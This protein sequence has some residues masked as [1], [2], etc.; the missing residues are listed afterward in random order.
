MSVINNIR[1]NQTKDSV[2]I[3]TDTG[4]IVYNLDPFG[5]KL[6]RKILGGLRLVQMLYNSNLYIL[7]GD[8]KYNEYYSNKLVIWNDEKSQN[9][10]EIEYNDIIKNVECREDIMVVVL[11]YKT[12]IYNSSDYSRLREIETCNNPLGLITINYSINFN[13]KLRLVS[14]N[15]TYGC[16]DI[17]DK[18]SVESL[19]SI[20]AHNN[21][22][23]CIQLNNNGEYLATA[24]NMGTIIRLFNI[25]NGE[26]IS[27]FR[28]SIY[29]KI[30]NNLIFNEYSNLLL[31]TTLC[32]S[33]DIFKTGLNNE[34]N[35]I[36]IDEKKHLF[37]LFRNNSISKYKM[38]GIKMTGCFLG[39]SI[40]ML[41]YNSK[42]YQFKYETG[43]KLYNITNLF[44]GENS[45]I[46]N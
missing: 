23:E 38:N 31:C 27:E 44:F 15:K 30:V 19:R 42:Y 2:S 26:M 36:Q 7:I 43:L 24:S 11:E 18:Q 16:V 22:L 20:Q 34:I 9:E 25:N 28:R 14:P 8:G 13:K 37:N 41:G 40:I 5:K 21:K 33:I 10:V 12:I 32:G 3:A 6:E 17:W 35:N 46:N 39:D 1:F 29:S 45:L 4:F